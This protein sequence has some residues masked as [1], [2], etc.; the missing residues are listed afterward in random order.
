MGANLLRQPLGGLPCQ[1]LALVTWT[2]PICHPPGTPLVG[3]RRSPRGAV[4][5]IRRVLGEG[6]VTTGSAQRRR[7]LLVAVILLGPGMLQTVQQLGRVMGLAVIASVYASQAAPGRFVPGDQRLGLPD[8]CSGIFWAGKHRSE[9]AGGGVVFV[10][11]GVPH[12]YLFTSG[13]VDMLAGCLPSGV[14]DSYRRPG[15][16]CPIPSPMG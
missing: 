9:L 14:E 13:T 4:I 6:P 1:S 15:G 7:G 12:A 16:T 10:P 11:R 3:R 5:R 8:G 2:N